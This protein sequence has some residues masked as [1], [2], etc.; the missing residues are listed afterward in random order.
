MAWVSPP[1]FAVSEV[2]TAARMNIL[3]DDL[4]YLKGN[5]GAVAIVD[6]LS[7][8]VNTAAA[9]GLAVTNSSAN[10]G[11][12]TGLSL[13]NDGGASAGAYRCSS[14]NTAYGGVNSL[15]FLTI[16]AHPFS[17]GTSNLVRQLIDANGNVGFG[18]LVPQGKL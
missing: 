8:T 18:T 6:A 10:A 15:N 11:A 7:V 14:T 16:G 17:I 2:V 3:S 5:A 1:T 13:N 12:Y 9:S 4:S